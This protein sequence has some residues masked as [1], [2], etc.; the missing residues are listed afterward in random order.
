M[1]EKKVV[2][3]EINDYLSQP[4]T[5]SWYGVDEISFKNTRLE[6]DIAG[7]EKSVNSITVNKLKNYIIA[8]SICLFIFMSISI[9]LIILLKK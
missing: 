3:N 7:S 1:N 9:V 2:V 5:L 6:K 4:S 8:L